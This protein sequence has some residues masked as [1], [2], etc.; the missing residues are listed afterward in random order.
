LKEFCP[1]RSSLV[2]EL[3]AATKQVTNIVDRLKV[4]AAHGNRVSA[5]ECKEILDLSNRR[6]T[7]MVKCG[8]LL[9]KLGAH[10]AKHDC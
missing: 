2:A 6:N 5:E 4:L 10:R 9:Q 7:G 3:T 1:V 8:R